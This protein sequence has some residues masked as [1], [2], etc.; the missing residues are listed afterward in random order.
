MRVRTADWLAGLTRRHWTV[1]LP[2]RPYDDLRYDRRRACVRAAAAVRPTLGQRMWP[3]L[4]TSDVASLAGH[5][6]V[7]LSQ[8]LT[9]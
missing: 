9:V 4:A 5:A 8:Q 2:L 1:V 6:T 7:A 3:P